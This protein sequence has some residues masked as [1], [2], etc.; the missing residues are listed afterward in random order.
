M[1]ENGQIYHST[2]E[3]GYPG[4]QGI[5]V[6]HRAALYAVISAQKDGI[7][8]GMNMKIKMEY[9][10]NSRLHEHL[11]V[12]AELIRDLLEHTQSE[13]KK[14]SPSVKKAKQFLKAVD[15]VIS[16]NEVYLKELERRML[17]VL[18]GKK[19]NERKGE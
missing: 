17:K 5:F 2:G 8:R 1:T 9:R 12:C 6:K 10:V 4:G 7:Y 15:D 18:K 13:K 19:R 3:E 11:E 14:K 16:N